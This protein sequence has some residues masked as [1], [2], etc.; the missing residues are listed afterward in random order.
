MCYNL[1]ATEQSIAD[2]KAYSSPVF[3]YPN[4]DDNSVVYGDLYQWGRTTDGHEKRTS[5]TTTTLSTNNDATLP[6]DISGA[7]IKAPSYPHNW[8]DI[9]KANTADLNW[10]SYKNDTYDPCPIGWRVPAQTEWCDIFRVGSAPG[11]AE[12]A[13]ANTWE[14][15]AAANG[16]AGYEIKPDGETTTLFLPAA[17]SR[18]NGNSEL[19]SVG[20]VGLYWSG[21][22]SNTYSLY[23]S[24]NSST[25]FP[26]GIGYRAH[27]FSVR[28]I[29]EL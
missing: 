14:W 10:R 26:T 7:F 6:A 1:G 23:L 29:A 12:T 25:V 11:A 17:G 15:H 19:Y 16:T 24:F 8:V 5:A 28:C 20:T 18:H 9:T 2:Q 21:S 13:V 27:G 22:I 4:R 3:T